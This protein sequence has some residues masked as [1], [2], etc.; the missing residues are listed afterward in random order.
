MGPP[1]RLLVDFLLCKKSYP[2]EKYLTYSRRGLCWDWG[3]WDL[4]GG[5]SNYEQVMLYRVRD[6]LIRGLSDYEI[7]F[8]PSVRGRF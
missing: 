5:E 3:D 1:Q 6:V 7:R 4:E 2:I 8:A